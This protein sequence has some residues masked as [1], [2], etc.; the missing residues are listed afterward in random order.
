M[1]GKFASSGA[2]WFLL[3]YLALATALS[4]ALLGLSAS[5]A[6]ADP[7][8][9]SDCSASHS[10]GISSGTHG[11]VVSTFDHDCSLV[12][13]YLCFGNF[14]TDN[15]WPYSAGKFSN[16]GACAYGGD[17]CPDIGYCT[18]RHEHPAGP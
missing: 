3:F 16:V 11:S 17:I 5:T 2:G 15:S 12:D 10:W 9:A 14:T 6:N 4:V 7:I 18:T 1:N 13:A 8:T